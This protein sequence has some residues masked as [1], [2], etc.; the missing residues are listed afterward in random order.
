MSR[1]V[2]E[3]MYWK[4]GDSI[5]IDTQNDNEGYTVVCLNDL[6]KNNIMENS[7]VTIV[8]DVEGDFLVEQQERM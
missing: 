1:Y 8:I 3:G 4:A 5:Y 2:I 6:I 7:K